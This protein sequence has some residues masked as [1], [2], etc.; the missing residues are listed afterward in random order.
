MEIA[1]A[2]PD[3]TLRAQVN[4][5]LIR[6][7]PSGP[8]ITKKEHRE[9]IAKAVEHF[10]EVLDYYIRDKE[11]RGHQAVSNAEGRVKE[12]EA[13]F[14]EHV[15]SLVINHLEPGGFYQLAYNTYEEAMQR[16]LFLRN[17]I[18]NKGGHKIFYYRGIPIQRETDLQILF[19]LTWFATP[20]DVTREANDGR[21]PADFKI[22]RGS[23]DKTI[24]EFKLA[25]NTQLA[26]NLQKQSEIYEKASDT[27]HPSI[28]VILYFDDQQY[29]RVLKILKNLGLENNKNIVLIDAGDDNKPSGS[30]A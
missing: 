20:S 28:K 29:E 8:K 14:I 25:K 21:G 3:A 2:L 26:R 9:A 7:I 17:V 4:D 6:H 24:V 11:N 27:T 23:S 22:S 5:Y 30:R 15:R 10:P 13:V 18:E 1:D 16:V 19:R 12:V